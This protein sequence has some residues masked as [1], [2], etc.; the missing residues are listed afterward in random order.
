MKYAI[1]EIQ[2]SNQLAPNKLSKWVDLKEF[3]KE[4]IVYN[5]YHCFIG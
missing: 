2:S 3:S 5:S 4:E 1:T